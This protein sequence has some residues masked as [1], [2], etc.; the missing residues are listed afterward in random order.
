MGLKT[1]KNIE[2]I[3]L[4]TKQINRPKKTSPLIYEDLKIKTLPETNLTKLIKYKDI[5]S[6]INTRLTRVE[7]KLI[8]SHSINN[9]SIFMNKKA[10]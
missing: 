6:I 5:K 1:N 2:A 9:S 10:K 8:S 3:N 4:N 7:P